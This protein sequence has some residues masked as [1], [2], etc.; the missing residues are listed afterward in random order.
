MLEN[1][2]KRIADA[3]EQIA[4]ALSGLEIEVPEKAETKKAE[5][6]KAETKKAEPKKAEP[7]KAETKKAEPKKSEPKNDVEAPKLD[8]V[9][10]AL[11]AYMKT[12]GRDAAVE[13]LNKYDAKRAS[14]ISE[15]KREEFIADAQPV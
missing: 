15:D 2:I 7:K 1:E 8:D 12:E 10:A 14:D 13:L 3:L 9:V 5:T 11:Q 4:G 6:K